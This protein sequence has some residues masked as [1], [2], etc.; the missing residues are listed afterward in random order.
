MTD[1]ESWYQQQV[2]TGRLPDKNGY[3]HYVQP[4]KEYYEMLADAIEEYD[5]E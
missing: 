1:Y 5:D 2:E 3:Y 4:P